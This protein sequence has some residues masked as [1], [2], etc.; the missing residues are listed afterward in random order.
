MPE[1]REDVEVTPQQDTAPDTSQQKKKWRAIDWIARGTFIA[2]VLWGSWWL[3]TQVCRLIPWNPH[4]STEHFAQF[5]CG[6]GLG[7]LSVGYLTLILWPSSSTSSNRV[8]TPNRI[9]ILAGS[10]HAFFRVA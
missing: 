3:I 7:I 5:Y 4:V 8:K 10:T 2:E 6:V 9:T 1:E